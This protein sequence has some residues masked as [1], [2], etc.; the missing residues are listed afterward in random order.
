[1][2]SVCLN[3]KTKLPA[4]GSWAEL[5][6]LL[7]DLLNRRNDLLPLIKE[8]ELIDKALKEYFAGVKEC[9]I[10][11]FKIRGRCEDIQIY[12]LPSKIKQKYATKTKKWVI[13]IEKI[14][15]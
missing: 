11:K 15:K 9:S 4:G 2:K 8:F 14:K 3:K 10:D 12:N 6:G 13:N 5:Y 7:S 1:M